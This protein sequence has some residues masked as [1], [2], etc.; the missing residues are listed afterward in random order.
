[1]ISTPCRNSPMVMADKNRATLPRNVSRKKALTPGLPFSPLRASLI[2]SVSTRYTLSLV[3]LTAC[4]RNPGPDR[5]QAWFPKS[6]PE[7][8]D[9]G[10][11][12]PPG[13]FRDVPA[14]HSDC[15]S[16]RVVSKP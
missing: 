12:A 6:Q 2:T 7:G 13:V 3:D 4:G 15:A 14:Q 11:E 5:R 9:V 10:H 8:G 1:M 16:Q